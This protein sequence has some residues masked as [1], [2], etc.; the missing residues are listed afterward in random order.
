MAL[1]NTAE[2][3]HADWRDADSQMA[4]PPTFISAIE[5]WPI[6][7]NTAARSSYTGACRCTSP[8]N[9]HVPRQNDDKTANIV[10][11]PVTMAPLSRYGRCHV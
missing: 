11:Q 2:R 10:R 9:R 3:F 7:A 6:A 5:R 4:K 1:G 8:G